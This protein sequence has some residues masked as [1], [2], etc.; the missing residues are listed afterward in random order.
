MAPILRAGPPRRTEFR[1]EQERSGE[2]VHGGEGAGG[3]GVAVSRVF[4]VRRGCRIRGEKD[5][6]RRV[7]RALPF[8]GGLVFAPGERAG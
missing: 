2:G 5:G 3:C 1:V 7:A 6:F 4:R 8:R